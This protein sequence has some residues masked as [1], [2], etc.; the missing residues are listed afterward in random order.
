MEG[1][2]DFDFAG[3]DL[4]GFGELLPLEAANKFGEGLSDGGF[5][6]GGEEFTGGAIE[7]TDPALQIG[8]DHAFVD[9]VEDGFEEAFFIGEAEEAALDFFG[10]DAGDAVEEFIEE[11]G[12]HFWAGERGGGLVE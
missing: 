9:G 7:V 8:D 1:I 11:A 3:D 2:E 10:P 12:V 4:F 5:V 6:V